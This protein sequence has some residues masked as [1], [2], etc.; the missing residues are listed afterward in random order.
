MKPPALLAALEEAVAIYAVESI[1]EIKVGK[2][3]M[4]RIGN[5]KMPAFKSSKTNKA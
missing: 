2:Y 1:A 3:N 5:H 4:P